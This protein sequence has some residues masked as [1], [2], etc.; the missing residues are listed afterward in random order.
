MNHKLKSWVFSLS[1]SVLVWHAGRPLTHSNS[2][3][4][5][6]KEIRNFDT[7]DPVTVAKTTRTTI[8]DR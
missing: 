8:K 4:E 7:D 5:G 2:L 6:A 1:S 3:T